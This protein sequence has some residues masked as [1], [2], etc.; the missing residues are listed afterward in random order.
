MK[1]KKLISFWRPDNFRKE[2]FICYAYYDEN[3]S[4]TGES[5]EAQIS[6]E[7]LYELLKPVLVKRS[8]KN[9]K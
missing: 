7:K 1:T 2:W 5:E 9:K 6:D 4:W 3:G 8:K